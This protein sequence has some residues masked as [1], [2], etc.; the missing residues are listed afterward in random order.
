MSVFYDSYSYNATTGTLLPGANPGPMTV[1]NVTTTGGQTY[2]S[3]G[4][5]ADSI[6][7][8]ALKAATYVDKN[9]MTVESCAAFCAKSS[10]KYFA[11]E[12]S[13][14][15]YCDNVLTADAAA[16]QAQD[17]CNYL[18]T[19]SKNEFCGGSGKANLYALNSAAS[20]TT[21]TTTASTSTSTATS[22][23]STTTS[24][25]V[26]TT[27]SSSTDS[28]SSTTSSASTTSTTSSTSTS[29]SSTPSATAPALQ[30]R[31]CYSD[32]SWGRVLPTRISSLA[33]QT[34]EQC[35]SQCLGAGYTIA[36]LEYGV[37]C[38]CGNIM[39]TQGV[40]QANDAPCSMA[41]GGNANEMCGSSYTLS[42][43]SNQTI[44]QPI[45]P[46][47][48]GSFTSL[49]C[50]NDSVNARIL[51][52]AQPALGQATSLETCAQKCAGYT[53]FGAEYAKECYCG[54]T[55]LNY[56]APQA[57]TDCN[58]PC[59]GN[60]TE[61]C[62]GSSR[63]GLYQLAAGSS[64]SSSSSASSSTSSTTSSSASNP[65][66]VTTTS[67]TSSTS[68]ITSTAT[69]TTATTT[70]TS[71]ST[72]SSSSSSAA[73]VPSG[74]TALGCYLDSVN[75]RS[76]G[77]T[78]SQNNNT[79]TA[80]GCASICRAKGYR[81]SG[82]EYATECYC[83]NFLLNNAY[84]SGPGAMGCNQLCPGDSS[85]VCGGSNRINIMV[86][87]N[88]KQSMFT[89]NQTG[90]WTFN[91]CYAD[92]PNARILNVTLYQ[93]SI[94]ST[95][96][97]CLAACAAKGLTVCGLQYATECFGAMALPS[98]ST[99]APAQGLNDPLERGCNYGCTGNGTQACGGASRMNLYTFD[100]NAA[101]VSP[102]TVLT[103][104]A[105]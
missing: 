36:G 34:V 100:P 103:A 50:Y 16:N 102:S 76:L 87:T 3:S 27:T 38:W 91:D 84:N 6:N 15:C 9:A 75:A 89:V 70:T 51:Q 82:V 66:G 1:P 39:A 58:M 56:A 20:A 85:Q 23:T 40:K 42:I 54:N 21:S 33:N 19:G 43:Y 97:K 10:Y 71:S 86:D 45:Q 64:S 52:D 94:A 99:R 4:C 32:P 41:C 29:S 83:D 37:E 44:I 11:V 78:V 81:F 17:G 7:A 14:E 67:T 61:L 72:T 22:T 68:T 49:G 18:C 46:A 104:A 65:T 8:R 47:T 2:T 24:A 79:N 59:V 74:F 77:V 62:G 26:A 55:L 96:E 5:I 57:A 101:S 30:Y 63:M 12:Y 92:N 60:S 48:V 28:S 13:Q 31:G 35:T 73:P 98:S 53:Y 95:V 69:T 93:N 80:S 88:W 25:S 105:T 90:K